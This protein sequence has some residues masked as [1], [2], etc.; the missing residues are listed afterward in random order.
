MKLKRFDSF[1]KLEVEALETLREHMTAPCDEA[2]AVMLTGGQTSLGLYRHIEQRP[3]VA[4]PGLSVLISDERYV[5]IESPESNYGGMQGMLRALGV[6]EKRILRVRTELPI[7]QA[8]ARYD[9]QLRAF[10]DAGGRITFGLLGLGADGHVASLFSL[11]D[12]WR[13]QDH[14][15]ISVPRENGP[16]RIS[17][18]RDLLLRVERIV[19][20]VHG[21][22][23]SD[24]V[25]RLVDKPDTIPAGVALSGRPDVE[26]WHCP[27]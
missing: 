15:A 24:A 18:T 12:V 26:V 6:D 23:K 3:F 16:D 25:H 19:F 7:P 10:L 11:D 8:V 20:L 2:H 27:R 4:D 22:E 21:K 14:Y 13:G 1:S 5:T 17:V 9:E